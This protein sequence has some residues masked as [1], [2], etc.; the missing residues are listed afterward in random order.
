M[1]Q[2]LDS[3]FTNFNFNNFKIPRNYVLCNGKYYKR[4]LELS[5][6]EENIGID[7]LES[8]DEEEQLKYV[9]TPNLI[10]KTVF[11]LN[12]NFDLDKKYVENEKDY[13]IKILDGYRNERI[14][15]NLI[16]DNTQIA[17]HKHKLWYKNEERQ[18]NTYNVNNRDSYISDR[19][20][21]GNDWGYEMGAY[22]KN[23]NEEDV[24]VQPDIS[25][26]SVQLQETEY[27]NITFRGDILYHYF[28]DKDRIKEAGRTDI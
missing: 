23:D 12:V 5:D 10:N 16:L 9:K 11:G 15:D 13:I 18:Y 21:N 28:N 3:N 2:K 20:L 8:I 1:E 26:T 25:N 19:F 24:D 7:S 22:V 6:D 14:N 27:L 4:F 17:K